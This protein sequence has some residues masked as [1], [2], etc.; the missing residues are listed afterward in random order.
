MTWNIIQKQK[1]VI[2]FKLKY[3]PTMFMILIGYLVIGNW[4]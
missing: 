2:I 4:S 3:C 1:C